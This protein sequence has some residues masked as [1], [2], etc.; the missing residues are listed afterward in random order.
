MRCERTSSHSALATAGT[1]DGAAAIHFSVDAIPSD[2]DAGLNAD[3]AGAHTDSGGDA[4]TGGAHTGSRS[5]A[6]TRGT[7]SDARHDANTACPAVPD[8]ARGRAVRVTVDGGFR[9]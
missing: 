2:A 8:T 4:N 7:C 1:V 6:N 3:A 5:N 9:R